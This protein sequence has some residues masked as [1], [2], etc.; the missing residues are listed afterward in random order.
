MA[1]LEKL[2][3]SMLG[4]IARLERLEAYFQRA[5]QTLQNIGEQPYSASA[6]GSGD[7]VLVDGHAEVPEDFE[8]ADDTADQE[9]EIVHTDNTAQEIMDPDGDSPAADGQ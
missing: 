3:S 1:R 7:V 8:H 5:L 4:I 6:S 2:E 9:I